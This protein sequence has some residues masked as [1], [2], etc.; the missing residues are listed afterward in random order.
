MIEEKFGKIP[1]SPSVEA[2]HK[3]LKEKDFVPKWTSDQVVA[4]KG[5]SPNPLF[6]LAFPTYKA[7]DPKGYALDV[8]SSIL[9]SGK[10]ASL[11]NEYILIEK[12]IATSMYAAHQSLD[13]SGF[14]FIGGELVRG[15]KLPEF[16]KNLLQR[17]TGFCETEITERSIQK[18]K[19]NYLTG[20]YGGLDTNAGLGSFLGER[21]IVFNDWRFY[22]QELDMYEKVTVDD[23]KTSCKEVFVKPSVFVSVWNMHK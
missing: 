11:I 7:G 10:S 2:A 21:Q 16:R 12:P 18:I 4:K 15:V 6:M 5:E 1:S 9:G 17:L 14:F 8:L 3:E 13:K 19:N 20:L 22:K 23:V